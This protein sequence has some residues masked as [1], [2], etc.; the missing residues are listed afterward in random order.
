[1]SKRG[2]HCETGVLLFG[3]RTLNEFSLASK[4]RMRDFGRLRLVEKKLTRC[5]TLYTT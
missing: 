2:R 5:L 3:L 1:M 4:K